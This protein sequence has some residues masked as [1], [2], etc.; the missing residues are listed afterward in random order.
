LIGKA[1]AAQKNFAVAIEQFLKVQKKNPNSIQAN[2]LIA[3]MHELKGEKDEANTYYQKILDIH[4]NFAPAA[5]NL[6]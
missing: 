3:T 6:A 4:K 5:N 1:Y 2:M